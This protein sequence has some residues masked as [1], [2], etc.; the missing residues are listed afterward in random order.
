MDSNDSERAVQYKNEGNQHFKNKD[1]LKA[2]ESYTKA[3]SKLHHNHVNNHRLQL[4]RPLL[5]C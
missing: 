3:I 1:Y 2:I 4:Y 5:L